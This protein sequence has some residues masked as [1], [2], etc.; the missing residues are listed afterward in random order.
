MMPVIFMDWPEAT[1][2]GQLPSGA[3]L[4][5]RLLQMFDRR[6]W[7]PQYS[8]TKIPPKPVRKPTPERF[9]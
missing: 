2:F 9:A 1:R 7:P 4:S 3:E 5:L 6:R 8:R